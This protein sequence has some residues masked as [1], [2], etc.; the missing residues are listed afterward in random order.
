MC[1]IIHKP[2]G[3][4]IPQ[5]L[6]RAAARHN[7]E[8]W[9]MMGFE[10]GGRVFVRKEASVDIDTLLDLESQYHDAEYALHLRKQ[11][12]GGSGLDN[13]H[14]FRVIQGIELMH[15][16]TLE[17]SERVPG[18]SDTWHFVHDVLRPLAQRHPGLLSDQAFIRVLELGLQPQNK[19]ALLDR[20]QR[21]IVL[22]NRA[23]GAEFEGLWLSS[24]RWIDRSL[25]P[26]HHAPQPQ[27]R[28]YTAHDV[29][30][31]S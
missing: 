18:R 26:L 21:R 23:H 11:T 14:P 30:F 12:R 22:I 24:T 9:G 1:L 6:L 27:A 4:R 28:D 13:V 31:S 2:A 17:L 8:G 3:L 19:A 5:E 15:N 29:N 20:L 7:A 25:F 10:R 16:G